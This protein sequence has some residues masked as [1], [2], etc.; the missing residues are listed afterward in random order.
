M[1]GN[2]LEEVDDL[3]LLKLI[4]RS[5]LNGYLVHFKLM[6]IETKF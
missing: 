4:T 2:Q 5:P 6:T 3:P 1:S